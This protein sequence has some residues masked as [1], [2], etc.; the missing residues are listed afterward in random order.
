MNQVPK[1]PEIN[2]ETTA[3][4]SKPHS[5]FFWRIIHCIIALAITSA[6]AIY[7]FMVSER[8]GKSLQVL[9]NQLDEMNLFHNKLAGN[10][11][12]MISIVGNLNSSTSIEKELVSRSNQ[13]LTVK[14]AFNV[15][16]KIK[17]G[18]DFHNELDVMNHY[19]NINVISEMLSDLY[20]LAKHDTPS[21]HNIVT[22]LSSFMINL[23]GN[24]R[25]LAENT[26]IPEKFAEVKL[27][28]DMIKI[29]EVEEVEF[30]RNL[31]YA[32][33]EIQGNDI[34]QAIEFLKPISHKYVELEPIMQSLQ[35]KANSVVL[36]EQIIKQI[37]NDAN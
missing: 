36:I 32:I 27:F 24:T 4:E 19:E 1:L 18:E 30:K 34:K 10:L 28:K 31:E 25:S 7:C 12:Q 37:V 21:N 23:S 15:I 16:E 26:D 20:K 3:I 13:M 2:N 8:L 6:V 9:E 33:R 29:Q 35:M 17:N 5:A 14:A 22:T 11:D